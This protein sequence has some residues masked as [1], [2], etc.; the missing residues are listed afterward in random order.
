MDCLRIINLPVLAAGAPTDGRGP[1]DSSAAEL[2]TALT[3][4]RA[5]VALWVVVAAAAAVLVYVDNRQWFTGDEFYIL[6]YRG[7]TAP[8]DGFG[9]LEPH[10]EHWATVP[11]L[12]YRALFAGFGLRSYWPYLI[13][14][15]VVHLAIVVMLWH[16]MVRAAVDAWVA[17]AACAVF[18]VIGVGFET[19]TAAWNAC[20]W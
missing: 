15:F 2:A 20:S 7:L 12:L 10:F 18:A 16:V 13:A 17:T 1:G 3:R 5:H 11:V 14:L 4:R 8:R 19:L 9:L 6:G